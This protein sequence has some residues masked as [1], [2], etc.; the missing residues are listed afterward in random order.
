MKSMHCSRS[1]FLKVCEFL[2]V[3]V[4]CMV[5]EYRLCIVHHIICNVCIVIAIAATLK[6]GDAC[7]HSCMR[8]HGCHPTYTAVHKT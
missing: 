2:E 3:C 8:V 7:M 4:P 5:A 1:E 6:V